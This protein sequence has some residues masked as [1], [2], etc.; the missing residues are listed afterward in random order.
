MNTIIKCAE[1]A[2]ATPWSADEVW[3]ARQLGSLIPARVGNYPCY[4]RAELVLDVVA[5]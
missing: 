2:Y 5:L 3:F 4:V 1:A